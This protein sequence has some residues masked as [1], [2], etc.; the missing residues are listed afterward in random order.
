MRIRLGEA[1]AVFAS[2]LLLVGLSLT[3]SA[4]ADAQEKRKLLRAP[5]S[6][7]TGETSKVYAINNLTVGLAGGLPEGTFIRYGA[8]IARNLNDPAEL[9]VLPVITQ[10]ATDNIKDLLY[11]KGIDV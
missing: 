7:E 3:L 10:G 8:E 2:A 5:T 4:T 6:A 9:R 11:L 1:S